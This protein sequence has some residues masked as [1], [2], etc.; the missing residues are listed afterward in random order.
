M[1]DK[2][3]TSSARSTTGTVSRPSAVTSSR[4]TSRTTTPGVT[5]SAVKKNHVTPV[6]ISLI[7]LL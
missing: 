6:S 7:T 3:P 2:N 4:T 5:N 1:I